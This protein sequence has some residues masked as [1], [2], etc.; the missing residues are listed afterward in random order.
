MYI[1]PS[2]W[3][4]KLQTGVPCKS[5]ARQDKRTDIPEVSTILNIFEHTPL[6]L[7]SSV[8]SVTPDEKQAMEKEQPPLFTSLSLLYFFFDI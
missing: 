1:L 4:E 8:Q 7:Y 3:P 6:G 2:N 5:G